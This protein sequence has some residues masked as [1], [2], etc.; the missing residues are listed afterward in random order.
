[1][2]L[3]GKIVIKGAKE[4]NLKNIDLTIPRDK[5][6]VFTGLSGSGKSTL[7]FDTIYAEGQ[8]RYV[9]SLSA[10]A[11]QFLGQMDKPDVEYIDGLSPAISIDQ[12]TTSNNPRSTVGT[13]TEIYDYLRLLFARVGTVYCP[14]CG[15]EISRVT[16]QEIVN[17][18]MEKSYGT[19]LIIKSPII[20]GQKGTHKKIL[21]NIEKDG[22]VR[23]IIDGDNYDISDEINLDKNKKHDIQVVI[24]RLKIKDGIESRLYD[25]I[26]T[27][28][29]LSNGL[30]LCDFDGNEEIYTTDF[31][32]PD[33]GSAITELSTRIFSFNAPYGA[34]PECKGLGE[35]KLIDPDLIVPDEE[36]SLK[37]GAISG[38]SM[39]SED[40]YYYQ[41]IAAMAKKY[42]VSM[43]IPYKD[44]PKDFKEKLLYS[45]NTE[46]INF[47]FDSQFSG[48]KKFVGKYEGVIP[49]LQRRYDDTG[50]DKIRERIEQYMIDM[51]CKK[52]HGRRL[53]DEVLSIKV[54]SKN[55]I[56]VTDMSVEELIVFLE[57]LTFSDEKTKISEEIIKEIKSRASFLN[58][59]GLGYLTLSRKAG[60][61]SGGEAQRIRLATQIGSA[62]VGVLYVLDEPSI[63]LH[64]KDNDKLIKTLRNLTDL[65]NTLIV[66]EHDD[67][68]I[69]TADFVVDIGPKA[70]I[71]GGEI[72]FSGTVDKLLKNKKSLTAQY[73]NGIR[74]IEIPE[75]VRAGKGKNISII[76]ASENNLKNINIDFPL[77]KFIC[78][79]GVSG[80]GKSTLVNEVFYKSVASKI[81]RKKYK[82]GKHKKIIG[83]EEIDKVIVVDQSPIGRTPHSNPA[84]YTGVFDHIRELFASTN[85]AKAKGYQKSRF[86]FNLKGGRC[87]ACKGHG[88]KRIEMHFLPDV[89]VPCEVCNGSR[90][91]VE[92]LNVKYKDKNISDVLN[93]NI[94]E[95]HN[96]FENIPNIQKILRTL[97]DVGLGYIKL[98]QPSTQLSGGEA[99]RIKLA[100]ELCKRSTGKTLYILDEPTTGLHMY[101]VDNLLKVIQKLADGGNT[102]VVIEH[103]MDVIKCCDHIIDLGPDGGDA[104]GEIIFEGKPED[105]INCKKSYTGQFLKKIWNKNV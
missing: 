8:R 7:A 2:I 76:G 51:P 38:W 32:C 94:E 85:Q 79:T 16:I 100:S 44:L 42:N 26:E 9:E 5:L 62:L 55:I 37:Q 47:I 84:T 48:R 54:G 82:P 33:H 3:A 77:G 75:Y 104:G 73:L 64:S 61:L 90:Y 96:F 102:V 41:M 25:S 10:Y 43:D 86:S 52:C 35:S 98:G 80:S 40:G 87:E 27:A 28:I 31:S 17:K 30:V 56:E 88:I 24:D 67:E 83:C 36:L 6:I 95:A 92:T 50:S 93:M 19:K 71:H 57:G 1:M 105:I 39:T 58:D 81:Y 34:C 53:K 60:T 91:N 103:N 22:Y 11:R 13:V 15:R 18:I 66:V 101:D 14:I 65:G 29:N 97:L 12:K 69:K 72:V 23:L 68:T 49:N 74:K 63:G 89:Y 78:V 4:N 21:E 45:E 20:R 46:E 70:G 59:V 99:Q